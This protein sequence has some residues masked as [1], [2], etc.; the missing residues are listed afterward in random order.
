MKWVIAFFCFSAVFSVF[1]GKFM[2]AGK[3]SQEENYEE[4]KRRVV[5][6]R[7]RAD[8]LLMNITKPNS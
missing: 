7:A 3:S 5:Q 4:W 8:A 1:L 6:E 2:K